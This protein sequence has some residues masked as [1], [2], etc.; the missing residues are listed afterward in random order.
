[1]R[2]VD[3][4]VCSAYPPISGGGHRIFNINSQLAER[5]S[6]FHFSLMPAEY[7]CVKKTK[8]LQNLLTGDDPNIPF[9]SRVIQIKERYLQ[10]TFANP[11]LLLL[12]RMVSR[13]DLPEF[14]PP[15]IDPSSVR[16]ARRE[17]LESDIVQ[18]ETP[19]PFDWVY[20]NAPKHK[21]IVLVEH[22]V[23]SRL[24][25]GRCT[26]S[27]MRTIRQ[28]EERALEKSDLIFT[29]SE[30]DADTLRSEYHVDM[31]KI[32]IIPHGVNTSRMRPA[33]K[34]EKDMAK[35][36]FGF[37]GRTIVLFTG[38]GH[39]PNVE[40]TKTIHDIASRIH[41]D[42]VL[43]VIAGSVGEHARGKSSRK[44]HYTGYVDNIEPYFQMADIAINP[45]L[46][47]GGTN[48]KMIEYLAY[49]LPVVTTGFGARGLS[50][51]HG[52]GVLVSS[53]DGFSQA[54]EELIMNCDM[55]HRMGEKGRHIAERFHDWTAIAEKALAAY[56]RLLSS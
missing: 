9:R 51:R 14:V 42:I 41:D 38:C 7:V 15:L 16:I 4:S 2:I 40:A 47:G 18:V 53:I 36:R 20:Q 49:G 45:V 48:T 31:S 39:L 3:F 13:R 33:S 10:F 54:I 22:D 30:D 21:P 35:A 6:I 52:E 1:M 29:V 32:E 25:E 23:T 28:K 12:G 24:Y 56:D 34:E 17:I 19:W 37:K 46:S 11:V 50:L 44:I 8:L 27:T 5:C 43:F 55:R 26:E